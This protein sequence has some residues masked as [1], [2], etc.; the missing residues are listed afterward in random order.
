MFFTGFKTYFK[1]ED[2][3]LKDGSEVKI[4]KWLNDGKRG[5][6]HFPIPHTVNLYV[7]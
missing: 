7:D 3:P 4:V 5:L 2:I 6:L 1:L